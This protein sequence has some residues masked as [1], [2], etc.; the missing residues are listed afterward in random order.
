MW[1][2]HSWDYPTVRLPSP[3]PSDLPQGAAGLLLLQ[4]R[5]AG[6]HGDARSRTVVM[7]WACVDFSGE[8][9]A[10]VV[11]V[12]DH[13]YSVCDVGFYGGFSKPL[14][15]GLLTSKGPREQSFS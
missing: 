14:K 9:E 2:I 12:L 6:H 11:D 15:C 13:C 7:S 3:L 4:A 5:D 8:Q 10:S 1:A